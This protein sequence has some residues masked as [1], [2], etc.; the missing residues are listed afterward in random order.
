MSRRAGVF[1]NTP[2]TGEIE[3]WLREFGLDVATL[4]RNG[5]IEFFEARL[6]REE[7]TD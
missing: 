5:A 1:G 6:P 2:H 4:E 7:H 3:R